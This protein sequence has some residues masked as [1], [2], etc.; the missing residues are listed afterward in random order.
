[1]QRVLLSHYMPWTCEELEQLKRMAASRSRVDRIAVKLGRTPPAVRAKASQ[2]R[3]PLYE[4]TPP[5]PVVTFSSAR[6]SCG[7]TR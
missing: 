2:E 3:I 7:N 6:W 5:P 1:M 4:R